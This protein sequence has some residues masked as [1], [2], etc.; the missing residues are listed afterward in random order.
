MWLIGGGMSACRTVGSDV[1]HAGVVDWTV[2]QLE[3]TAR[4]WLVLF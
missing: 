1:V 2:G 4:L 3:L